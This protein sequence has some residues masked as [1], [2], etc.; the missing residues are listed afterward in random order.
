[1]IGEVVLLVEDEISILQL[2]KTMLEQ[3]GFVVIAKSSPLEMLKSISSKSHS[4]RLLISDVIMPEMN[5]WELGER[6][7][8]I[9]PDIRFLFMSGYT[10]DI[11]AHHGI[12]DEGIQFIEKPFSIEMLADKIRK[13]LELPEELPLN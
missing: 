9:Y 3:I 1:M 2:V 5:G 8:M 13:V 4:V 7:Q 11:I 12:L 6:I 10:A